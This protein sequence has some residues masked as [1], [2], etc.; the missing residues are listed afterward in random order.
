MNKLKLAA[1]LL[2]AILLASCAPQSTVEESSDPYEDIS[3]ET[4]AGMIEE[5][6]E[7]FLLI[8]THI[9][10]EGDIPGT[11][12][13]IPFNEITANLDQLPADKDAEIVLYCRSDNMSRTA[14]EDLAALGYTNLKNLD[15]GF[16]AWRD[17]G[18]PFETTP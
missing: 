1:F 9:P 15:G 3:M 12:R 14:A 6:R 13:A 8:N 7:S 11:D 17:A 16:I 10:Y 4:L 5:R 18:Y 2:F